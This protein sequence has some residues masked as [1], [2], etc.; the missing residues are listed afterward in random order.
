MNISSH[1][2]YSTEL[3]CGIQ[4]D[5]KYLTQG[6]QATRKVIDLHQI[7]LTLLQVATFKKLL[8]PAGE[9]VQ[10]VAYHCLE[11]LLQQILALQSAVT[12]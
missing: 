6:A 8:T 1:K 11:S 7:W 2:V 9:K 12:S 10:R 3:Q 5:L 4:R